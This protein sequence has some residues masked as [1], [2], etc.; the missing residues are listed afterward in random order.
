MVRLVGDPILGAPLTTDAGSTVILTHPWDTGIEFEIYHWASLETA[1]RA[2]VR[3]DPEW[4]LEPPSENSVGAQYASHHT[5]VVDDE[6][7]TLH[8]LVDLC[9]ATAIGKADNEA[10]GTRSTYVAV[11]DRFPTTVEIAVPVADGPARVDQF[12]NG[13]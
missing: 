12:R 3:F 9:G 10:L 5:L 6:A 2:D 1:A 7:K 8:F 11:G 13:N 4:R